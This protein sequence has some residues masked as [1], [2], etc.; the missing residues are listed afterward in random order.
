MKK[1]TWVLNILQKTYSTCLFFFIGRCNI[2]MET[3][4]LLGS[5]AWVP[6]IPWR[7]DLGSPGIRCIFFRML[8]EERSVLEPQKSEGFWGFF[9]VG[10]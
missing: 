9:F 2:K 8:D 5:K 3:Y 4:F 1:T 7:S 10:S 6:V